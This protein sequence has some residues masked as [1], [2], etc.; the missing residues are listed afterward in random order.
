[1]N[2]KFKVTDARGE[3]LGIFP[4]G[5]MPALRAFVAANVGAEVKPLVTVD[6]PC[7]KHAAYDAENCP[8]CGTSARI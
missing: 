4:K 2:T 3:L 7:T 5:D 1:M 6:N 8:L